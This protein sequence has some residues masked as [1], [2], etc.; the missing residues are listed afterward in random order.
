MV[1]G[2]PYTLNTKLPVFPP[3]YRIHY[4]A[5]IWITKIAI[6]VNSVDTSKEVLNTIVRRLG[7]SI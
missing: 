4:H 3:D 1:F 7:L 6:R 2:V 5:N